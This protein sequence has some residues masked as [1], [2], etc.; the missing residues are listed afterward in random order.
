MEYSAILI[1]KKK[2]STGISS[3]G[4]MTSRMAVSYQGEF[5]A[6]G[7][8][9]GSYATCAGPLCIVPNNLPSDHPP[10]LFL[11][12][13]LDITVPLF[14][15][16]AYEEKLRDQGTL[17]RKVIDPFASHAWV[18]GSAIEVLNWFNQFR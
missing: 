12:G 17:T 3:G 18:N 7:V 9:A 16:E 10:T 8:C 6:L 1:I 5:L 4:Y 2:I 13:L 14:T 11:H 15:M